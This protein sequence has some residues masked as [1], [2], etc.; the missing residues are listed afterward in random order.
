MLKELAALNALEA[1]GAVLAQMDPLALEIHN[2]APVGPL[3]RGVDIGLAAAEGHTLPGPGKDKIRDSLDSHE[4][5]GF[6]AA[7]KFSLDRNRNAGLAAIGARIAKR[8]PAVAAAR[9]RG[10]S[11]FYWLG[12]DIATGIFG[13]PALG[14]QGNTA[15]GQGSLGIRDALMTDAEK[16]GFNAAVTFHLARNYKH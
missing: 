11:V 2:S 15:T 10:I 4:Q 12:F 9:T 7:V 8:D 5:P 3:R 6:N 14:A 13:D 16:R 1:R